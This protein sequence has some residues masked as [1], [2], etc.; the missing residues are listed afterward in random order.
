M[1]GALANPARPFVS[2][3][4]GKK[5]G[6]KIGACVRTVRRRQHPPSVRTQ[7]RGDASA[8]TRRSTRHEHRLHCAINLSKSATAFAVV[9]K[10]IACHPDSSAPRQFDSAS[11][12]KQSS[13]A[14][15]P[16]RRSTRS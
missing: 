1:G 2:I 6:D 11:S 9:E 5:V 8:E 13:F 14:G 7:P 15:S 12:K 16:M 3:L 4:G 10:R